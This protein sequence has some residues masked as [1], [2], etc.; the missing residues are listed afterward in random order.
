MKVLKQRANLTGSLPTWVRGLKQ[1]NRRRAAHYLT[2]ACS[3][4]AWIEAMRRSRSL[5]R[6]TNSARGG[7]DETL[8]QS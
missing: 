5:I 8:K 7:V 1:R 4:G 6:I 2:F 3:E